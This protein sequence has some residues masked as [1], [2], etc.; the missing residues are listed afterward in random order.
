M[1]LATGRPPR[2]RWTRGTPGC[3]R[4]CSCGRRWN[5]RRSR[6]P[7]GRGEL[8]FFKKISL[9]IGKLGC[10]PLLNLAAGAE[11]GGAVPDPPPPALRVAAGRGQ[12]H[13]GLP[14][15]PAALLLSKRN[16]YFEFR[17]Y[18][19]TISLCWSQPCLQSTPRWPGWRTCRVRLSCPPS[20]HPIG[21]KCDPYWFSSWHAM[22]TGL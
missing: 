3:G 6:Q 11:P 18:G 17:F 9:L 4:R 5:P 7:W 21:S 12:A 15:G 14:R 2:P 8:I 1:P 20:S 16:A 19:A 10:F 22:H 13:A